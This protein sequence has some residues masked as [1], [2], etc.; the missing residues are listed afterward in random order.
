MFGSTEIPHPDTAKAKTGRGFRL[1]IRAQWF[2]C[3]E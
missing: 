2:K 1:K 3:P